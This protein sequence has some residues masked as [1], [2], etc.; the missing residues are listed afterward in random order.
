MTKKLI[1]ALL[2][3]TALA[4]TG[5]G[6]GR[7]S[8]ERDKASLKEDREQTVKEDDSEN[9]GAKEENTNKKKNK[10]RKKKNDTDRIPYTYQNHPLEGTFGDNIFTLGGYYTIE[11]DRTAE[12]KYPEL[13]EEIDKYNTKAEDEVRSF[14]EG[15]Q[16]EVMEMWEQG[17]TGYYEYDLYLHPV[18]A[19]KKVFSFVEETYEFYG[20]AHGSTMFSGYNYD[21]ETGRKIDFDDVVSDT[22]D[23]PKIIV[24][25]LIDQNPDLK[26]YF[27][28]LPSDK[29]N[30]IAGIPDRLDDNAKG[31]AWA[32]DYDGIRINFEDYAMG[33]YAVG[34]QSV[35]IRFKD[36]PGI[37]TDKYTD[38]E[39]SSVPDIDD[40]AVKLDDAD[41]VAVEGEAPVK[42]SSKEKKNADQSNINIL[43]ISKEDQ[44]KM[45]MF[46]SNFAEQRF[47]FYDDEDMDV[48]AM[49]EFAYMW[50]YINKQSN[51]ET[52]GNYYRI[53]IDK[54]KGIVKKY[55]GVTLSNDDLYDHDW[56]KSMYGAFCKGGYYY[57]PAADGE[58]FPTFAVVEQAEDYGE[59]TL[60]LYFTT[61]DLDM[62][63]YWDNDEVI[64]KKYYSMSKKEATD[65]PDLSAGYQG[66][67][68]VEKDGDSY[69]LRYYEQ[70]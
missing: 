4:V 65:S 44:Y 10:D 58:S 45:N 41:K 60:W 37:F 48:S 33:A 17:F 70:Y 9:R 29:D 46:I 34:V 18:R 8:R 49:A 36:H 32:L 23:L 14:V 52:E 16:S 62:D 27:D 64:P 59:G 47:Q 24:D 11:L 50:S 51:I 5:C 53:S 66:L 42:G 2:M 35:K 26:D 63:I 61:Y 69:K 28:E 25:E 13:T 43:E 19:D 20:G 56:D 38:Y 30:L 57:V 1:C 15:S 6:S 22:S 40:I 54:V 39:N 7:G 3:V 12:D 21:P 68:I 31:L 67:A 55:F